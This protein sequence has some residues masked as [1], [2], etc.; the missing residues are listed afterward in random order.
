MSLAKSVSFSNDNHCRG[1]GIAEVVG[2]RKAPSLECNLSR[3]VG[4]N[5]APFRHDDSKPRTSDS[6]GQ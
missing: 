1:N 5:D 4:E 3:L 2:H 6:Q